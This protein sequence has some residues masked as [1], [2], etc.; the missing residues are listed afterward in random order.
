MFEVFDVKNSIERISTKL[1][2][3]NITTFSNIFKNLS[4]DFEEFLK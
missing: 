4:S 1:V 2:I 3:N